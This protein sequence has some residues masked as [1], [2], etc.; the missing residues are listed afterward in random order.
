MLPAA[1]RRH[2]PAARPDGANCFYLKR[3]K[4]EHIACLRTCFHFRLEDR[5]RERIYCPDLLG[6]VRSMGDMSDLSSV[7]AWNK[8]WSDLFDQIRPEQRPDAPPIESYFHP[9]EPPVDQQSAALWTKYWLD[10]FDR[11]RA[12]QKPG[13]PPLESFFQPPESP[14]GELQAAADPEF[15]AECRANIVAMTNGGV[16]WGAELFSHNERW[17]LVWR[18]DFWQSSQHRH[19]NPTRVVHWR[20]DQGGPGTLLSN[21]E[22]NRLELKA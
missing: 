16:E 21:R 15:A 17:G 12:G 18:A 7:D 9:P 11:I 4:K 1:R 10:F 13:A 3:T 5:F 19:L 14:E 8:Y 20:T 22:T 6:G 2:D